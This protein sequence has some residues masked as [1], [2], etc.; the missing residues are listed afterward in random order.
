MTVCCSYLPDEPIRRLPDQSTANRPCQP[1]DTRA[2]YYTEADPYGNELGP[3]LMR[4]M[5][6]ATYPTSAE[7]QAILHLPAVEYFIL[8]N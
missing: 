8:F 1:A 3:Q 5:S 7:N 4:A 6:T 2:G